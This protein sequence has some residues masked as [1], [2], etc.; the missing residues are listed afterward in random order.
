LVTNLQTFV[1][2]RIDPADVDVVSVT[3]LTDGT[4]NA[5]PHCARILG[6]PRSFRPEVSERFEKQMRVIAKDTALAYIVDA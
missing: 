3:R 5:L 1:L 2:R 6:D 4:R